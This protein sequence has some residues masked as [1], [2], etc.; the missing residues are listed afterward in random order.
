MDEAKCPYCQA[1]YREDDGKCAECKAIFPWA[2]E[3]K[4]LREE[5]K[6]REVNRGRATFTLI[7]EVVTHAKGGKPVSAAALKGFAF[8][9]LFPRTMIVIGSIITAAVLIAQTAIIYK[10]TQ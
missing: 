2:V 1:P 7:D 8:A 9:W 3:A 4:E 10:Q 5:I 6:S